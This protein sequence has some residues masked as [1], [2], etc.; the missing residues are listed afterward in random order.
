MVHWSICCLQPATVW[1]H[2]NLAEQGAQRGKNYKKYR[3]VAYYVQIKLYQ[4]LSI[5]SLFSLH[6][7]WNPSANATAYFRRLAAHDSPKVTRQAISSICSKHSLW[8]SVS[9]WKHPPKKK[10]NRN[11]LSLNMVLQLQHHPTWTI[12]KMRLIHL[13]NYQHLQTAAPRHSRGVRCW[14]VV[15][16]QP[17]MKPSTSV[18]TSPIAESCF[19]HGH[20]HVI[21]YL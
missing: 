10:D 14:T 18:P 7:S 8:P 1:L 13:V 20:C 4:V 5:F 3:K 11:G 17:L 21:S 6:L 15:W 2:G 19:G 9:E 16:P 12:A